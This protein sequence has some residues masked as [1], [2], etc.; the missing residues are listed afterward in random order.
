[1]T[2]RLAGAV[3]P[4]LRSH[5]E[6]PVDWRPWG[7][8][9]LAEAA[10]RDVPVLVSIGYATCHWCHVMARES[11]SDPE[12]AAYLNERFVAIKVDRE[13]H[14]EVDAAFLAA[15]GAFTRHLGWPL[16]AFATPEGRTFYAGTYY[17]PVAT[18]GVPAFREVLE[19][20][21]EAWRERRDEVDATSGA[22]AEALAAAAAER[23]P[24]SPVGAEELA[25]AAARLAEREDRAHG[26]FGSAPKFPVAPVL[27]FLA[28]RGG[29]DRDLAARALDAMAGS[30]LRD[31]VEGGFF[32]Y[33]VREDWTEPHYERMLSDNAQLLDVAV[34]LGR[35][36]VA[37]GVAGF[38]TDV[39]RLPSGALASAQDSESPVDGVRSE[40]GYYRVPA[41]ERA[42]Q[43][44]PALDEKVLAGLN[45]LAI[46]ALAEAGVVLGEPA[47]IAAA[48]Q[49]AEAVLARH[50]SRAADGSPRLARASLGVETSPAAATLEDYGGLAGGL[51]RLA[52]A[53]G[54][55]RWA[56]L[57]RELVDACVGPDGG[58][59]VPG[60]G[61]PALASRGLIA[62]DTSQEGAVPSGPSLLADAALRLAA[63][64][65]EGGYRAAAGRA[66]EPFGRPLPGDAEPRAVAEPLAFGGALTVLGRLARPLEQ[67]VVVRPQGVD[68]GPLA[69]VARGWGRPAGALAILDDS[70]AAAFAAAGFDLFE[71]RASRDG[72]AV[73]YLCED[74]VCALPTSDPEA[75]VAL[76]TRHPSEN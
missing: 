26:G 58:I 63:L 74:A 55:P 20:V 54:E 42:R 11:F 31:P 67:L 61:D 24:A 68:A 40:G 12:L 14:P 46:G 57:A 56:L 52:L 28:E 30:E 69:A 60:G 49:A 65:S 27:R 41:A 45:G 29:G 33:A 2:N 70:A 18:G 36:E 23:G 10:A 50:L 4:Y 6:N 25:R 8:E 21:S 38:L 16:T 5:A 59:A 3:S 72:R 73:A 22:V 51:V 7:E 62:D 17:P 1:M 43:P 35:R 75:L 9:A 64:T 13:E 15:A 37:A 44:R 48:R 19:A 53:T 71:A 34:A 76:L 39:L 32:R 47:W 66:V